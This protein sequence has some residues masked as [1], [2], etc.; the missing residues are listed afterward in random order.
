VTRPDA[1]GASPLAAGTDRLRR[2][3]IAAAA[4]VAVLAVAT[5]VAVAPAALAPGVALAAGVGYAAYRAPAVLAGARRRGAVGAAP[6]VISRAVL[7]MRVSP[8]A[9]RAAAFA[10]EGGEGPLSASLA[11]HVR[12]ARGTP[13]TGLAAF[14]ER[15]GTAAPSLRRATA[16]VESA[17]AAPPVD[18]RRTLDRATTAVL[19]GARERTADAVADL[20][21]PVTALYAFGVLLPLALV[22]VLPAAR[23]AGL[24]A[25]LPVV[26]AVDD[27]LLPAALCLAAGWLLARRPATFPPTP[28]PPDHPDLPDRRWPAPVAGA[29][30]GAASWTA[31][32]ALVAAWSRPVA[33]A[34]VGAGVALVV[35]F[36]PAAAVRE[37][38]R[39]IEAGL[40]D[41]L[42]LVGRRVA[43]GTA[44]EAAVERA[45]PAVDGPMGDVLAAAARR[46]RQ[47]RIGLGEAFDAEDGAL[48]AVPSRRTRDATALLAVA[49]R[50]GR[51]AGRAVV[52]VADHL[53][54]LRSVERAARRDLRRV[55]GTLGTTAAVFGPLV[56]GTTVAL[57]EA[58]GGR[59]LGPGPASAS[60]TSALP[61][62]GL[63][64]AVGAYVILLAA[65]LT[66][67]AAG[68][69]RGFDRAVVGYRV[70]GALCAATIVFL[71]A[72][73]VA[74]RLA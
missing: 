9:E 28:V 37:R 59:T 32:G 5:A 71:V 53:E 56:A 1:G 33:A 6:A 34:G 60:A 25:T 31:A 58:T 3:G 70:G 72:F 55:T 51:P 61:T 35:R 30:A 46:Q 20:R 11:E 42:Y 63:G 36:R 47:L 14:G 2:R 19:E 44:V 52:A 7:Y 69:E 73:A 13:A 68:I 50:E 67:L 17:A 65:V 29:V 16:L 22:A 43:E 62:A 66:A 27:V 23:V 39:A 38:V 48:A 12:R 57:A 64:L 49:A 15:W 21:G 10:A 4:V 8:A 26:V 18:R 45:A 41:A 54:E 40:P 74:G 24:P